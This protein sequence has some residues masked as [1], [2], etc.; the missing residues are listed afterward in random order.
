M[1]TKCV[2]LDEA[3]ISNIKGQLVAA[4]HQ[5]GLTQ[6]K[7]SQM[8]H[9]TQPMVCKYLKRQKSKMHLDRSVE[10]IADYLIQSKNPSFSYVITSERLMDNNEYFLS[11]KDSLLTAEKSEVIENMLCAM[12]L[13]RNR[14]FS[15]LLPK[16]KVNIAMRLN[17]APSKND[18]AAI[19]SGLVF[20][21][22]SLKTYSEP[23]F[24]S[25]NHLSM[26]LTYASGLNREIRSVINIKFSK[27][28]INKIKKQKLKFD[29]FDDNYKIKT[30]NFDVLIHKGYF[31]IEPTTYVFGENAV[32]AIKKCLNLL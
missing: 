21:N 4:L 16:V 3:E 2:V 26:I 32:D 24:G 25:S 19:P 22:G 15:G 5:R 1:Y 27:E 31:G 28:I 23:E 7:I 20:V 11:T 6:S 30:K 29:F 9:I 13:L 17:N 10:S 18:I 8:I 12:E 14:N